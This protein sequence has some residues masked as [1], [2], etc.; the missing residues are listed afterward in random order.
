MGR[1]QNKFT[2]VYCDTGWSLSSDSNSN[3][4]PSQAR[5][6]ATV[7]CSKLILVPSH[8]PLDPI[9]DLYDVHNIDLK[10]RVGIWMRMD[11]IPVE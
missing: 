3:I 8:K 11:V 9:M 7:N 5:A 2:A 6:S 1:D 4:F 10:K